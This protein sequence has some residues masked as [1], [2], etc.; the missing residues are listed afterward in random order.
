M[1]YININD[2]CTWELFTHINVTVPLKCC[3]EHE[4]MCCCWVPRN[5]VIT[6]ASCSM[7]FPKQENIS[8]ALVC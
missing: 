1:N 3:T 6:D 8:R 4:N 2:Y 5:R 7:T